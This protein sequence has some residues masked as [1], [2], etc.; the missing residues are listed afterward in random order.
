MEWVLPV[1]ECVM[2]LL[3]TVG[4]VMADY[5]EAPTAGAARKEAVHADDWQ[6][7]DSAEFGRILRGQN[8]QTNEGGTAEL[9][10]LSTGARDPLWDRELDA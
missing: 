10:S 3:V 1:V 7:P 6:C 4:T 2:E 5:R 8:R 9:A